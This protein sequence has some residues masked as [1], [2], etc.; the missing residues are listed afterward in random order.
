MLD[1]LLRSYDLVMSTVG[2]HSIREA[3]VVIRPKLHAVS[4]RQFSKGRQFIAT[5]RD[6][7]EQSLP[8]LRQFLP[9]I[10]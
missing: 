10:V 8:A 4:L 9:W 6:A 3:H 5:G 2:M 7:V 1:L